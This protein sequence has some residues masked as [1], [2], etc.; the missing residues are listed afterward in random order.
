M[1]HSAG[2]PSLVVATGGRGVVAH[3]GA[4]LLCEV[5]DGLGLTDGCTRDHRLADCAGHR[6]GSCAGQQ[7]PQQGRP[8][9]RR[10]TRRRL[11]TGS[12]GRS[13]ISATGS[14]FGCSAG[15]RRDT[16]YHFAE[17]APTDVSRTS[18]L[19]MR[20]DA[21]L[22]RSAMK[23]DARP[24]QIGSD[25]RAIDCAVV[26]CHR[27]GTY[28]APSRAAKAAINCSTLADPDMAAPAR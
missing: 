13:I 27:D 2:R 15:V 19:S 4:R 7:P 11:R 5:A 6:R 12:Q 28:T 14:T 26:G 9:T 10:G 3:A 1:K 21:P 24:L 23:F 22:R 8:R 17:A 20:H 16:A 25:L 18:A